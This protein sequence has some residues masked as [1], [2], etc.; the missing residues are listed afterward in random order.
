MT[1]GKRWTPQEEAELK[2]LVEA[3][4]QVQEIAAKFGKQ[5][6]AIF[7]KCQR[8]GLKLQSKGY[9]NTA[10]PIPKELLSIEEALKMIVGALKTAVKPG[11]DKIEV[12]RLQAVAAIVKTYKEVLS[13][14]INY[15]EIEIKLKEME[16]LNAQ[17]LK[18]RS[19]NPAPQPDS[20]P[21]A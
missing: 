3:N 8:L 1:K 11:L 20:T 15:R 14:Y 2:A 12:Q 18:E 13:D 21:V 4:K 17:L 10:V 19:P 5:P 9:V 6:G 16:E 7:I